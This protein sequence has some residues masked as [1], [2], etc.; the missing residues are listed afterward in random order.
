MS[1]FPR[2]ARANDYARLY[3]PLTIYVVYAHTCTRL[4]HM[5]IYYIIIH[6]QYTPCSR[7]DKHRKGHLISID[8]GQL[9]SNEKMGPI[10][11]GRGSYV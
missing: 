7:N 11:R 2:T 3:H 10:N 9:T 8:N 4:V 1:L 5:Y 6:I